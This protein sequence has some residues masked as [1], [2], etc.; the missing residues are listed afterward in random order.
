MNIQKVTWHEIYRVYIPVKKKKYDGSLEDAET[1]FTVKRGY[2][3]LIEIDITESLYDKDSFAHALKNL[4]WK[5][6]V[7]LPSPRHD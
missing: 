3:T 4:D 7:N 5:T 2:N 1:F 6:I